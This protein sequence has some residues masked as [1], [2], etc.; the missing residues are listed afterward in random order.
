VAAVEL[1]QESTVAL[2]EL[3]ND[4][5]SNVSLTAADY[6]CHQLESRGLEAPTQSI[7]ASVDGAMRSVSDNFTI[8]LLKWQEAFLNKAATATPRGAA[9][10]PPKPK[11]APVVP[12]LKLPTDGGEERR[13]AAGDRPYA[14]GSTKKPLAQR[15]SV[16][17]PGAGHRSAQMAKDAARNQVAMAEKAR[18]HRGAPRRAGHLVR[19]Q[20]T[21]TGSPVA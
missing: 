6:L 14:V 21:A 15:A 9:P 8:S 2:G 12:R 4:F 5:Q 13:G 7:R 18:S 3:L 1:L 10:E 19:P 17:A 11:P 20:F 16:N